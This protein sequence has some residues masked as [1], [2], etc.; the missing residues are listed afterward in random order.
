MM[1]M[2]MMMA[3]VRRSA[4]HAFDAANNAAGDSTDDSAGCGANRASRA[5]TF[6]CASLTALNDALP[7]RG[8]RHRKNAE[9]DSGFNQKGFH[10]TN[11][12]SGPRPNQLR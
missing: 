4:H 2:M 7:L 3:M 10:R 9:N 11:S 1:M 8:E 5:P 12:L 6:G